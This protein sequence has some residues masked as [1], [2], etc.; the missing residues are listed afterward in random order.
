[1]SRYDVHAYQ[2][3]G[4]WHYEILKLMEG[5]AGPSLSVYQSQADNRQ[6][7]DTEVDARKAGLAYETKLPR[8]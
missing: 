7:Y 2:E 4:R 6:G 1:M 8:N 5:P 3:A